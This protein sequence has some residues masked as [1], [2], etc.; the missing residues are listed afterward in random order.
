METSTYLGL[1]LRGSESEDLSLSFADWRNEINGPA[2]SAF[3]KI[4]RAISCDT[5]TAIQCSVSDNLLHIT[6]AAGRPALSQ[7]SRIDAYQSG[8]EPPSPDNIRPVTGWN[9]TNLYRTGENYCSLGTVSFK[10][11]K[12]YK[13]DTPIPAGEYSFAA[14]V[15]STDTDHSYVIIHFVQTVGGVVKMMLARGERIKAPLTATAPIIAIRFY[16]S[17]N[18]TDGAGDTATFSDIQIAPGTTTDYVPYQGVVLTAAL[19]ETVYGGTLDWYTGLLTVT[20]FAQTFDGTEEWTSPS[21]GIYQYYSPT[22][23][24]KTAST[25]QIAYHVCSHFEADRYRSSGNS[26]NS[27][28]EMN[29]NKLMVKCSSIATLEDWIAYLGAQAAAGTPVTIVWEYLPKYYTTIQLTPQQL[30]ML[31]GKNHV[32]SDCGDTEVSY[33]ADTKLYIDNAISL[34]ASA[35]TGL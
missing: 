23:Y 28:Y 8:S 21:T 20:H 4:D 25:N 18:Y 34:L 6:D 32:W 3:C 9:A 15:T 17:E 22:L 27:C 2:D 24:A 16:A 1:P 35:V 13:L 5:A 29:N 30:T 7:I 31:K 11:Y 26:D 10:Q 33:V 12:E 14:G 19:P